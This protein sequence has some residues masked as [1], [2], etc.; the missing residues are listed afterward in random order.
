MSCDLSY[1]VYVLSITYS[2]GSPPVEGKGSGTTDPCTSTS[3]CTPT[4]VF[5]VVETM[6]EMKSIP[7]L[8][9]IVQCNVYLF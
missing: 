6:T 5:V 4:L 8:G 2:S 3:S 1:I 7:I 9:C